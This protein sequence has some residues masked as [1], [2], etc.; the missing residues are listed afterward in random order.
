MAEQ[1]SRSAGVLE[2]EARGTASMRVASRR[3]A[4]SVDARGEVMALGGAN[5]ESFGRASFLGAVRFLSFRHQTI[6]EWR[7]ERSVAS[8]AEGL[9]RADIT[10]CGV[11]RGWARTGRE[12]MASPGA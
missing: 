6:A 4:N 7:K 10:F 3:D 12:G 8:S 9:S 1:R 11:P 2:G 5:R